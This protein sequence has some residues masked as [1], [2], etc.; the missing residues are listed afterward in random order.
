MEL[1]H[2]DTLEEAREKLWKETREM[3]MKTRKVKAQETPGR[4]SASDVVSDENIPPFD[5]SVVDGHA[6]RA[7]ETYG[8]GEASLVFFRVTGQVR[9]EEA[10]GTLSGCQEAVRLQTGSMIPDGAD[11][12]VMEGSPASVRSVKGKTLSVPVRTYAGANV[13]SGEDRR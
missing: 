5:R 11:A 9:I 6:V 3:D 8:A 1:L 10:A 13:S 7:R 4:I 12:V 2:T